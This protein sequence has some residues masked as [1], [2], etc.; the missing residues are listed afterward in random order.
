MAAP[1]KWHVPMTRMYVPEMFK[2]RIQKLVKK[3]LNAKKESGK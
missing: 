3:W 2:E 1:K